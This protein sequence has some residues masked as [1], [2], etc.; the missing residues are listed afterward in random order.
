MVLA[1]V[2]DLRLIIFLSLIQYK[3]FPAPPENRSS[4]E[5]E[6]EKITL[7]RQA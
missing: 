5:A 7:H 3:I 4:F 1:G 6:D 2:R